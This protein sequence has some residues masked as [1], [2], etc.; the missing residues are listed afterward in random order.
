MSIRAALAALGLCLCVLFP[1][2]AS[3]QVKAAVFVSGLNSPVEFVQDPTQPNVQVVVQQGGVIRVVQNGA[4]LTQPFLDLSTVVAAG[5]EQGL[6]SLAFAPDYATSR[7]FFVNFTNEDGNTVVARFKRMSADPLQADSLSRFDLRWG[8]PTGSRFIE[9]PFANHNGGHLAFGA[10]GYLYIGMGD[11]GSGG[12]PGNRAQ[13]GTTLLGKMLRI[14]INV[15]D[16]DLEGYVAPPDNPFADGSALPEIWSFGLRN[17]WKFTVDT[18][19]PGG[20]GTGAI[21]IADVGQNAHEEVNYEPAG[22]AGRN[23]GWRLREGFSPYSADFPPAYLPLTEPIWDYP[24]TEGQ[25]VTGGFVYRGGALTSVFRGRYFYADYVA[26]RVWS[27]GLSLDAT[28]EATVT[29]RVEHTAELSNAGALG[30]ISAFGMDS[31]GELYL[32]SH[33]GTVRKIVSDPAGPG[34]IAGLPF[35]KVDTPQQNA[36]PVEGVIAVTGW[37]L[38]DTGVSNVRVYRKCVTGV[39]DPDSCQIV[40]GQSVVLMGE[41][42]FLP[43]RR[44]DVAAAFPSLPNATGAGWSLDIAT[45]TLPQ[46]MVTFSVVAMDLD[47]QL[48]LLGQATVQGSTT[49]ERRQTSAAVFPSK[50]PWLF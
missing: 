26:G 6:L 25:S 39:D 27:L 40:L 5:G 43:G 10:D 9:Q 17:P 41:A 37:A 48:K 47:G 14:N 42:G 21:V 12:D 45:S 33:G 2:V 29:D 11:G 28:G 30:N 38:D 16:T 46:G 24:R 31:A 34:P 4:L 23:Y 15:L 8:G 3:G 7:R 44:P 1:S 50:Q 32:V 49:A 18:S 35:G 36:V 19:G 22:R 20:A 13:S